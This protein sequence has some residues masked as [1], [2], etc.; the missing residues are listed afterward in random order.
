MPLDAAG[1]LAGTGVAMLI[2]AVAAVSGVLPLLGP[3][4][5]ADKAAAVPNLLTGLAALAGGRRLS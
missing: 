4:G 1:V 3:G 5:A 2:G